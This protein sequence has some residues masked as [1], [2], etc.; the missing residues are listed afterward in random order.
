M[1]HV[2]GR[3]QLAAD[4]FAGAAL[5]ED[6]VGQDDGGAAVDLEAGDDVLEARYRDILANLASKPGMLGLIFRKSQN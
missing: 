2:A 6:V 4:R 1:V 5:E 3:E